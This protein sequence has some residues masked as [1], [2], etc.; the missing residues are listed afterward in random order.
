MSIVYIYVVVNEKLNE[1]KIPHPQKIKNKNV[2]LYLLLYLYSYDK[3]QI[4]IRSNHLLQSH[5]MED[6]FEYSVL[7]NTVFRI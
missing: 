1:K 4:Y 2:C 7:R 5:C 6:I 3:D